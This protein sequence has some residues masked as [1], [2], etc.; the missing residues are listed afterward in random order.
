MAQPFKI[1]RGH[2]TV[3]G[4]SGFVGRHL[5]SRLAKGGAVIRVA[6]RDTEGASF[7]KTFGDAGQ[8]VPVAADIL[9]EERVAA[10]VSGVGAVVNLVGIMFKRGRHTFEAIH[11]QGAARVAAAAKA[12]G[13][14][15][16]VH[17]SAIGVSRD[18]DSVYG[19][20]KAAGEAAVLEA[21][22]EATVVRPSVIFGPEDDFFNL[23]AAIARLS[24]VLPVFGSAP[25]ASFARGR[26]P[27]V[28]LFGGGGPKFQPVYVGDVA[29][30]I[31]KCL[32]DPATQGKTYELGGPRVYTFKELMELLLTVLERRRLLVP[33]PFFVLNIDAAM[34][35]LLRLRVITR[36]QVRLLRRDSVVGPQAL[37]FADLGIDPKTAEII[38]PTYLERFR[39]SGR[40]A[41][42]RRT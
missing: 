22:P 6:V 8:I 23:F 13:A 26:L 18:S 10:A 24:P 4:G 41:Y 21:F 29:D 32:E 40:F 28:D 35:E 9:D 20:T 30:A 11:H 34:L 36:D 37:T 25:K 19:R 38:L 39:R 31:V 7:L 17:V 15:R 14:Q 16:L 12:A 5:V 2:V 27:T 1:A 3:F 42:R 33:L